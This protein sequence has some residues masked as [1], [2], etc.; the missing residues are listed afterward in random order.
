MPII[1]Q[2]P[3]PTEEDA[4]PTT[5][6]RP[7]SRRKSRLEQWIGDQHAHTGG[8]QGDGI[9]AQ[10]SSPNSYPYL[11]YCDT[12]QARSSS[13]DIDSRSIPDSFVL[14]DGDDGCDGIGDSCREELNGFEV[15]ANHHVTY[16]VLIYAHSLSTQ[17][18][19][20]FG[21]RTPQGTRSYS[22]LLRTP[23]SLRPFRFSLSPSRSASTSPY[24]SSPSLYHHSSHRFSL[25]MG[26]HGRTFSDG[27]LAPPQLQSSPPKTPSTASSP[28]SC[29][30]WAFKRPSVLGAFTPAGSDVSVDE[31]S[32]LHLS[33]PRPS[34][35]SSLTFSSGTTGAS[36][37]PSS[38]YIGS[39]SP[40][41]PR[42]PN[43]SLWSLPP[44]AS[45]LH[46]PP[47]AENSVS[48]KPGSLKLPF[49]FKSPRKGFRHV[50]TLPI[51]R[52]KRK[53]KLV[54]SGIAKGDQARL[55]AVRKWCE[56]RMPR[57]PSMGNTLTHRDD[58]LLGK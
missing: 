16:T 46:D 23:P 21:L 37:N 7:I 15:R 5:P 51:S 45:H 3:T 47:N 49:S 36:T 55:E 30:P 54:V 48:I 1:V 13:C 20:L 26:R 25:S 50:P 32:A 56:V 12:R 44:D 43:H 17:A 9:A 19:P 14:V 4:T 41:R 52:D 31:G 34:F 53:K 28:R 39:P 22:S 57:I 18:P 24:D 11:T 10:G 29:G 8:D 42:G 33:P 27:Y 40:S 2:S 38:P 35:S 6:P 58:S